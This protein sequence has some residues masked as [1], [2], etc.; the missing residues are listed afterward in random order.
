MTDLEAQLTARN[1]ELLKLADLN[2]C[3]SYWL[4]YYF[5]KFTSACISRTN[6][7]IGDMYIGEINVPRTD[8]V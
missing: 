1:C 6:S 8:F 3:E 4:D 5:V 2:R 7:T